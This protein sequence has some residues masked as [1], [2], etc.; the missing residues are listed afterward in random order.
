[1][2]QEIT[3][4]IAE[5]IVRH[6]AWLERNCYPRGKTDLEVCNVRIGS[7]WITADVTVT[8]DDEAFTYKGNIYP[9]WLVKEYMNGN[10]GG[11]YV[12]KRGSA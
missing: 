8:K 5:A 11:C 9:Y 7:L 2:G 12:N 6:E 10:K 3:K 1:M 4:E